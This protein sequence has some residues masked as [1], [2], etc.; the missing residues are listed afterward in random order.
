MKD[1]SF[2]DGV[3]RRAIRNL[4]DPDHPKI[5]VM[6]LENPFDPYNYR[7][8]FQNIKR[9]VISKDDLDYQLDLGFKD[10]QRLCKQ[11]KSA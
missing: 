6:V 4:H 3:Y 2:E 7:L 1:I 9:A 11:N 5:G 8:E 10:Y